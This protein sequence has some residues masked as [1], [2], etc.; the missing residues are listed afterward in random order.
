MTFEELYSQWI[1]VKELECKRSTVA[2]YRL[3]WKSLQPHVA[4]KAVASFGRQEARLLLHTLLDS[5]LAPKSARDRMAQM[6]QMMRFATLELALTIKPLEWKLRYP[7]S[8]PREVK[9]FTEAEMLRIV[10]CS[11]AEI[12]HGVHT[13]LPVLISILTGMRLGEVAA[14]K[15]GDIDFVHN[16]ISVCRTAARIYDPGTKRQTLSVGT[17]KTKSG[18]R[19]IP[20]LP[21]LKTA[22]RMYGGKYP[23]PDSFVWGKGDRITD[24]GVA[25]NGYDRFLKRYRLPKVNFH[26]LRHTYATRLVESGGDIKT[27]STL[28]G[29]SDVS[30]TLN[31]YVHPSL[32]SKRRVTNKAFRKLRAAV[33]ETPLLPIRMAKV[34]APEAY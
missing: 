31:L 8:K 21:T 2:N 5:G 16:T 26:G 27:I 24:P 25:R 4:N 28:L 33:E 6:K 1:T 30:T 11:V 15:W 32:D 34:A 10:K 14:L 13:S 20:M 29:H 7:E 23:T 12:E 3:Q 22:L 9:N 18:F 17:P 19:E